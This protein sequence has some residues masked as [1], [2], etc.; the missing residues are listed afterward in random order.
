M[1]GIDAGAVVLAVD[2]V[3]MQNRVRAVFHELPCV[4]LGLERMG[5]RDASSFRRAS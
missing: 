3:L 1:V 5:F 4:R 2:N